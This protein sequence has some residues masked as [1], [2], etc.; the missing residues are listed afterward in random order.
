MFEKQ[1][2]IIGGTG[3]IGTYTIEELVKLGYQ[4][5]VITLDP[6]ESTNQIHYIC[7]NF[8]DGIV[9]EILKE[10]YYDAIIDF[11]HHDPRNYPPI[12]EQLAEHTQHL[13]YLSSYRVYADTEVPIRESSPRWID[14]MDDDTLNTFKKKNEYSVQK[15]CCEE[16]IRSS[17]YADKV[18]I[19][20]PLIAF[21]HGRLSY[22]TCRA[23][24]VVARTMNHKKII[25]PEAAK[26]ITA[27]Y[28]FSGNVGK[29][30]A[31]LV[32]N[33]KAYGEAYTLGTD[34]NLT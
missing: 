18:T 25:V 13:I 9:D 8:N 11:R 34:E 21:Y 15:G 5:D 14:V 33:P 3:A 23:S 10:K 28:C 16:I 7:R 31:H 24:I 1:I 22:I 6:L 29:Q 20:R 2:L 17:K 32:L 27:G 4:M 12:L 19:V 30:L 26:N